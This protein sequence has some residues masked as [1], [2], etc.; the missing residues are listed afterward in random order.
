M[1]YMAL[2]VSTVPA[3]NLSALSSLGLHT[4]GTEHGAPVPRARPL[5]TTALLGSLSLSFSYPKYE[6]TQ[7]LSLTHLI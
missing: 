7:H 6:V 1:G 5:A 3:P 4:L 2:A